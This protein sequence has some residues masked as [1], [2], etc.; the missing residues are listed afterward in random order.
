MNYLIFGDIHISQSSLKECEIIFKEIIGLCEKYSVTYIISLG[1]NFDNNKPT[2]SELNC[3]GK[4]VRDLRNKQIIL[5]AAQSHESETLELSSVDIYGI[6][7]P[8]V[9]I[10]KE[11]KDGN[12]LYCGHFSI[13]ESVCNYDAKL[14][15]EEFKNYIYVFLGHI[16][17][18]QMIKPNICHLGSCRYV[19]FD[20]AKDK[21]K[22]VALITDYG[23]ETE[24]VH[25]MKLKS[26][27]PMIQLELGNNKVINTPKEALQEKILDQ[28]EG[29][30]KDTL[31]AKSSIFQAQTPLN[32]K[33]FG[34][35]CQLSAFLDDLAPKTKIKVKILDFDSFRQF[36][37]LCSKYSTKFETFKYETNFEIISVNNQKCIN[38]E[39]TSFKESFTNWLKNQNIDQ[40]IKDILQKEVE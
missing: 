35:V 40:K 2:A 34:D 6:L 12:H 32:S 18:Y 4:F 15:K 8:N 24:K 36:F 25:F 16:H 21:Q 22:I 14:S 9:K 17:S 27:I 37:P 30:G 20:E 23:T 33:R 38:K 39:M 28:T 13:K 11:Y 29:I 19:N 5:L 26:P 10:V 1:D 7:S 31:E 3:L